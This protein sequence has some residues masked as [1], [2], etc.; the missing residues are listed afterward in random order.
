VPRVNSLAMAISSVINQGNQ[1][2]KD[3]YQLLDS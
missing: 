1:E 3:W 2:N